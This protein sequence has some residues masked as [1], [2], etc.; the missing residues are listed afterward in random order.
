MKL[1]EEASVGSSSVS[2]QPIIRL[3]YVY[4]TLTG[5][6]PECIIKLRAVALE[7][8]ED[9]TA[10]FRRYGEE[11]PNDLVRTGFGNP[12]FVLNRDFE[13]PGSQCLASFHKVVIPIHL[14]RIKSYHL[15]SPSI[16]LPAAPHTMSTSC[17]TSSDFESRNRGLRTMARPGRR[18]DRRP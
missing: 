7:R 4:S 14:D 9:S 6:I 1:G 13:G 16:A 11:H 12:G 3:L 15:V 18:F 5:Y 10:R 8:R 17:I 2:T